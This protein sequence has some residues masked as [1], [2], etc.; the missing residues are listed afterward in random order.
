[1][2]IPAALLVALALPAA[3]LA[4]EA[5]TVIAGLARAGDPDAGAELAAE[6]CSRCHEIGAGGAAKQHPPSFAAIAWFRPVDQIAA[7]I[8]FP[9]IH[10]AMPTMM[11]VLSPQN[12][13][14]LVAYIR[15]LEE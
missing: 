14:D 3:T 5:D 8:W 13:E 6:H 10:A 1:M 15:S 7:R 11:A 9:S 2:R 4:Q 12:V